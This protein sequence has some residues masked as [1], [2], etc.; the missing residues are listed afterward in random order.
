MKHKDAS[1]YVEPVSH[2]KCE[3]RECPEAAKFRASWGG[4][5]AVKLLCSAHKEEF[6]SQS[7]DEFSS[8][9]FRRSR[10]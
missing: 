9:K 5:I 6:E 2:G 3:V 8:S 4:G 7:F 10:A 1:L